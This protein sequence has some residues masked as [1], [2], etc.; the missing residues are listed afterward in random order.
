MNGS[1]VWTANRT[2]ILTAS[3]F[4]NT[5]VEPNGI[6]TREG[7]VKAESHRH[8]GS[9]GILRGHDVG[10]ARCFHGD[11]GEQETQLQ[12]VNAVT[13]LL[14]YVC[15]STSHE[16]YQAGHAHAPPVR[17]TARTGVCDRL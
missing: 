9:R 3:C 6:E 4:A 15:R 17:R 12:R 11:P 5:D 16:V 2:G 10:T 14:T 13:M 1:Q 8:D 7:V